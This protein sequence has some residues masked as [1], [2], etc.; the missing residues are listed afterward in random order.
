ME[1]YINGEPIKRSSEFKPK[2]TKA[3]KKE[4]RKMRTRNSLSGSIT[5]EWP[6]PYKDFKD[7]IKAQIRETTK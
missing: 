3:Q 5:V 7:R 4:W 6:D 2:L 1:I